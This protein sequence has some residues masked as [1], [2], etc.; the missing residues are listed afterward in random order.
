MNGAAG[1]TAYVAM[2]AKAIK[3]S[4]TIILV[5]PD[6]FLRILSLQ[7]YPLIIWTAGGLFSKSFRYLTSYGGFA[8]H[9]KS[10]TEL[11]LPEAAEL[12]HAQKMW[13]P[14]L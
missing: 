8:F 4:G 10:P 6:E 3:A 2:V 5:E 1:T 13:M 14:E 11:Q 9:C 12:I 7:E